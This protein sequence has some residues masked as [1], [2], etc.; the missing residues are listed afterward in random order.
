MILCQE[1]F[2]NQVSVLLGMLQEQ[3]IEVESNRHNYRCSALQILSGAH[4]C[5]SGP[6]M[7]SRAL[8]PK[9]HP[10]QCRDNLSRGTGCLGVWQW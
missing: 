7:Q 1:G 5:K 6:W 4:L 3:V 9:D 10:E 2:C 8:D